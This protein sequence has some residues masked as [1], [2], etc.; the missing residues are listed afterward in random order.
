MKNVIIN[1]MGKRLK[2]N[3]EGKNLYYRNKIV[4]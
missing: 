1:N 3:I 4:C 2:Y